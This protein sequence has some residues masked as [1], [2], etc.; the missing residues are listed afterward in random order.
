[1]PHIATPTAPAVNSV[2]TGSVPAAHPLPMPTGP[3]KN[4]LPASTVAPSKLAPICAAT[5]PVPPECAGIA[6]NMQPECHQRCIG[7]P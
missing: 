3:K 6:T 4:I 1:M 5:I 2:Q 7:I